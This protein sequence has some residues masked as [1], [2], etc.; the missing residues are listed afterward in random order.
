MWTGIHNEEGKGRGATQD[1]GIVQPRK[2]GT[3]R[4]KKKGE[5]IKSK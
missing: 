3:A 1:Q 4:V 5:K 2:K